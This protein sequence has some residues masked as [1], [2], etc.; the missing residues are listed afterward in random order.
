MITF[1]NKQRRPAQALPE[2]SPESE[3]TTWQQ[4]ALALTCTL[5]C[6]FGAGYSPSGDSVRAAP[7]DKAAYTF[8]DDQIIHN[9]ELAA[10]NAPLTIIHLQN[11][12]TSYPSPSST[13]SNSLKELITQTPGK[14]EQTIQEA[15]N[16]A[17][18]GR[19][20]PSHVTIHREVQLPSSLTCIDTDNETSST[21]AARQLTSVL[22][23]KQSADFFT[24]VVSDIPLCKSYGTS[25]TYGMAVPSL[26][27]IIADSS[28]SLHVLGH[29]MGHMLGMG[30]A[31][32]RYRETSSG[33]VHSAS[34]GDN[35][36]MM[37][38][39]KDRTKYT[40]TDLVSMGL[41][42]RHEIAFIPDTLGTHE[43]TITRSDSSERDSR[44]L[45]ILEHSNGTYAISL[46]Y[47]P[48]A[49]NQVHC[50]SRLAVHPAVDDQESQTE[51]KQS[52]CEIRSSEKP[53]YSLQIRALV[54]TD[55]GLNT[56]EL[57]L[58]DKAP[59]TMN[60]T[61]TYSSAQGLTPDN[62]TSKPYNLPFDV[63]LVSLDTTT[64][65]VKVHVK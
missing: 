45:L 40:A 56:T 19:Y 39:D 53:P 49:S 26:N 47:D 48:P 37:G 18:S 15:F 32:I 8:S 13:D 14:A 51:I 50:S 59:T 4:R 23:A 6:T 61:Y 31:G 7:G 1:E 43:Y 28:R 65:Q 5:A 27:T 10:A 17:T 41:L 3:G 54:G 22:P 64:A 34:T 35:N 60:Q 11:D 42:K 58:Q 20:I 21:L 55:R 38:Y 2:L 44:K 29:E 16:V 36:S 30:H 46:D 12:S 24:A 52:N 33:V 25:N 63:E 9:Q 62:P 57:Y